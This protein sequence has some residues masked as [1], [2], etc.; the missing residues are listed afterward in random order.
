MHP[1]VLQYKNACYKLAIKYSGVISKE[2]LL[3][4][5]YIATDI[6]LRKFDPNRGASELTYVYFCVSRHIWTC[7]KQHRRRSRRLIDSEGT[8]EGSYYDCEPDRLDIDFVLSHLSEK[9]RDM[10]LQKADGI[11]QR[12]LAKKYSV[13]KQRI[14]Q[15]QQQALKKCREMFEG[16]AV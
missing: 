16:S 12:I 13:S 4:E 14:S 7:L 6:A 8:P 3:Q 1:R 9:E 11:P 2:D 10:I 5:A 15:V